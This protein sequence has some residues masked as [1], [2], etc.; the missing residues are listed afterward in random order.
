MTALPPPL[1]LDA[2]LLI[3]L[4]TKEHEHH[5]RAADWFLTHQRVAVCPTVEGALV[6]FLVRLGE[7]PAVAQGVCSA[8][9]SNPA[10]TFWPDEFSWAEVNLRGVQGHRQL[11]DHYLVHLVRAHGTRLAT[12]DARLANERPDETLLIP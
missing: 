8:L 12:L 6:R 9:R 2:N 7:S 11:T 4:T 3:A 5:T 1:L 10:C